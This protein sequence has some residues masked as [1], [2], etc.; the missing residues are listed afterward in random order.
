MQVFIAQREFESAVNLVFRAQSFCASNSDSPHVR[1]AAAKLEAR[2][3]HLLG[4]LEVSLALNR[5]GKREHVLWE[6][7]TSRPY[8][9]LYTPTVS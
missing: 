6:P 4:V 2:T 1:V 3:K 8:W 5:S 7:Y 9:A